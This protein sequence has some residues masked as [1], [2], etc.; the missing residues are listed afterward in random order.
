MANNEPTEEQAAPSLVSSPS[1]PSLTNQLK[2]QFLL[3]DGVQQKLFKRV[4]V[5]MWRHVNESYRLTG[6]VYN[7]WAAESFRLSS[8]LTSL[9][10]SILSYLYMVSDRGNITIKSSQVYE[11][12]VFHTS[13]SVLDDLLQRLVKKGYITRNYRDPVSPYLKINTSKHR[14]FIRFTRPGIKLM[15]QFEYTINY[16]TMRS[17]LADVAERGKQGRTLNKK[18]DK[19]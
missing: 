10:L 6:I 16:N 18:R 2:A 11:S 7:Y 3:L 17:S 15:Q 8:S 12:G 19:V 4:F 5:W 13:V 9:E 1:L 14:I